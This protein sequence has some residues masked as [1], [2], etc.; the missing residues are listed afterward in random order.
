L[1]KSLWPWYF[2]LGFGDERVQDHIDLSQ[3]P[4]NIVS[5]VGETATEVRGAIGPENV[6]DTLAV[7]EDGQ[8]SSG[9]SKNKN[10][11]GRARVKN[12]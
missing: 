12:V 2:L 4:A 3:Q 7:W 11:D 6:A 1:T 8:P 10:V 5:E 9:G